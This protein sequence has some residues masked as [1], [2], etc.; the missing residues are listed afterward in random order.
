MI[1]MMVKIKFDI[2]K[3]SQIF[4]RYGVF[5]YSYTKPS[6]LFSLRRK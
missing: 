4:E 1:I 5:L 2:S 3:G 6:L